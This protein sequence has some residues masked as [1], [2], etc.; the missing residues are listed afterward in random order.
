MLAHTVLRFEQQIPLWIRSN[1]NDQGYNCILVYIFLCVYKYIQ[2]VCICVCVCMHAVHNACAPYITDLEDGV[3]PFN[4]ATA[5]VEQ[6]H[7]WDSLSQQGRVGHG[8]G[9]IKL[10]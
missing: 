6:W 5:H 1:T 7:V 9:S 4:F 10:R 3:Q 2:K 8:E